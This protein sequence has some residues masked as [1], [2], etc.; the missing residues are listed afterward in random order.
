M[1]GTKLITNSANRPLEVTLIIRNG[2]NPTD[3]WG[4][5]VVKLANGESREVTYGTASNIIYLNGLGLRSGGLYQEQRVETRGDSFDNT[6]NMNS[7]IDIKGIAAE[8]VT[9][10][11]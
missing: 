3:T 7:K 5:Q 2:D 10:G 11:N 1:S 8:N 9:G 4:T 6:L